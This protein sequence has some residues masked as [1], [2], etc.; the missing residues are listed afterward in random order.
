MKKLC[1]R[2]VDESEMKDGVI[3]INTSFGKYC[4]LLTNMLN[5][6][7]AGANLKTMMNVRMEILKVVKYHSKVT[8]HNMLMKIP[9]REI[10]VSI[11]ALDDREK[12]LFFS[13]LSPAKVLRIKEELQYQ[14]K[15]DIRHD[16]YLKIVNKFLSYFEPG[17]KQFKNQSY[18]RPKRPG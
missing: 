10:A 15:L 2:A 13:L 4:I 14:E 12:E 3:I 9:D 16:R 1:D 17:K 18:I 5:K 8:L 11:M 7:T 6:F